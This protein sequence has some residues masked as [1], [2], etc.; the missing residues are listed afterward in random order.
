M[1]IYAWFFVGGGRKELNF[2]R[3]KFYCLNESECFFFFFKKV[4][5]RV[6]LSSAAEKIIFF[7][8]NT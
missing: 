1:I 6:F 5:A 4:S 2:E 7:A 3:V 8:G